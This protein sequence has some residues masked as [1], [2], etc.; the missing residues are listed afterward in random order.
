VKVVRNRR[1]VREDPAGGCRGTIRP[2]TPARRKAPAEAGQINTG[3]ATPE[4]SVPA[5][6]AVDRAEPTIAER[7]ADAV[8]RLARSATRRVGLG[9]GVANTARSLFRHRPTVSALWRPCYGRRTTRPRTDP[10][11]TGLDRAPPER[12]CPC[13]FAVHRKS[14][15]MRR[16]RLCG[17]VGKKAVLCLRWLLGSDAPLNRTPHNIA[18]RMAAEIG[19]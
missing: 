3:D 18:F 12:Q 11:A 10:A 5:R 4:K 16:P 7:R 15:N 14:V 13:G 17:V 1:A 19:G 6:D 8:R 2:Q 9:R